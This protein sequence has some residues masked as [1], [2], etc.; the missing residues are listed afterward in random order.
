MRLITFNPWLNSNKDILKNFNKNKDFFLGDWC[1]KNF[2]TFEDENFKVIFGGDKNVNELKKFS[3]F[4]F[5][6]KTY[7]SILKTSLQLNLIIIKS[8]LKFQFINN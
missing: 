5:P 4:S 6:F 7:N 3:K 1:L 2:N 8:K